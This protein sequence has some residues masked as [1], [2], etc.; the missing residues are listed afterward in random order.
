MPK[1]SIITCAFNHRAALSTTIGSVIA[2]TDCDYEYLIVDDG[3][4]DGTWEV[5]TNWV[6][7]R[8]HPIRLFR[9]ETNQ[10]IPKSRNLLLQ[11]CRGEFISVADAGDILLPEKTGNHAAVLRYDHTIGVVCG[12]AIAKTLGAN[13]SW[14]NL[15]SNDVSFFCD[16]TCSYDFVISATTYRK[17][18]LITVGGFCESFSHSAG[19]DV[20]LKIGDNHRQH[21][22][23]ELS[24][25]KFRD[26]TSSSQRFFAAESLQVTRELYANTLERR[27][28]TRAREAYLRYRSFS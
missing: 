22:D 24:C 17:S 16:L 21:F 12:R 18:A 10:G 11:H 5:L 19:I 25:I 8:K 13:D 26:L 14:M 28:G 23:P 15:P 9:N 2:Q 27:F 3:S 4:T 7:S 1:T 6:A 20:F